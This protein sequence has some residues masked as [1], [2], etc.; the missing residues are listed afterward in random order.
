ME[1]GSA[2]E[3]DGE[4]EGEEDGEEEGEQEGEEENED[5]WS[6]TRHTQTVR[7]ELVTVACDNG[8]SIKHLD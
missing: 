8:L 2:E 1:G 6:R 3:E 7:R 4:E 5:D